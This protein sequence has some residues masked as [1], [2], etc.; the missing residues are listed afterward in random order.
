MNKIS[1]QCKYYDKTDFEKG[2]V[3]HYFD[4]DDAKTVLLGEC[5]SPIGRFKSCAHVTSSVT[6]I[7]DPYLL[8]SEVTAII[9]ESCKLFMNLNIATP[10]HHTYLGPYSVTTKFTV[11]LTGVQPYIMSTSDIDLYESSLYNI[12][13][14]FLSNHDP[15]IVIT[16]V[17]VL[18]QTLNAGR[19]YLINDRNLEVSEL[20]ID[21]EV[22]AYYNASLS[23]KKN[24]SDAI[25]NV[26]LFIF[27][28]LK[29]SGSPYFKDLIGANTASDETKSSLDL[30]ER[31]NTSFYVPDHLTSI[32]G[33][34]LNDGT[35]IKNESTSV[36]MSLAV[37]V[38]FFGII[39]MG[40]GY[41]RYS[42][43]AKDEIL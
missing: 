17:K 8:E 40:G 28:D 23:L 29:Y 30:S 18:S 37:L 6:V 42:N 43:R 41:G 27:S 38:L 11:A 9:L 14:E 24:I 1:I 33:T 20:K 31:Q 7:H 3:A 2:L 25:Y 39:A 32:D 4:V 10:F 13:N 36:A 34:T 12:S 16:K 22:L 21:T 35:D 15:P 5:K 26:S 19:K